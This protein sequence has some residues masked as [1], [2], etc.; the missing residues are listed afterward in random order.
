LHLS[1]A[2]A[3]RWLLIPCQGEKPLVPHDDFRE[4][5]PARVASW[6]ERFPGCNWA[7]KTGAVSAGLL[8]VDVTTEGSKAA[9]FGTWDAIRWTR[10]A[11]LVPTPWHETV[12][13]FHFYFRLRERELQDLPSKLVISRKSIWIKIF[14]YNHLV[15][16]PPSVVRGF[17]YYWR[18]PPG[19]PRH[20]VFGF[21]LQQWPIEAPGWLRDF[22]ELGLRQH[23]ADI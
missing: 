11:P 14:L 2:V 7:V 6:A 8:V 22:I 23:T 9:A 19:P 10:G 13:G 16:I 15:L 18:L 4:P 1:T 5:D 3:A 12:S 21:P 17:R 20:S